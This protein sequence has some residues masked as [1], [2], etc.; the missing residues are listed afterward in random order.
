MAL[1]KSS[2]EIETKQAIDNNIAL[3]EYVAKAHGIQPVL[4]DGVWMSPQP[5]P[6]YYP[7]LIT[8]LPNLD[9]SNHIEQL[10]D[11]LSPGWGIK[12]S[13]SKL[14]LGTCGFKVAVSGCWFSV[15]A[16]ANTQYS[17]SDDSSVE[18]VR[19]GVDFRRWITAW[20]SAMD[21]KIFPQDSW[22]SKEL[23]FVFV[24]RSNQVV[25][26]FLLNRT[27]CSIGLSNWFGDLDLVNW[28]LTQVISPSQR[29]V[30]YA[31]DR[32]LDELSDFG[33]ESLHAMNVWISH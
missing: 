15:L 20:D 14:D 11:V 7:N 5:M 31:N 9:I 6:P 4:I 1:G 17:Y 23:E 22:R 18:I 26:G 29:I 13:Y 12:D 24:K 8:T 25:G 16:S 10:K 28:A 30:G 21:E 33:F 2:R 19:N 32:E 3:C 27:S